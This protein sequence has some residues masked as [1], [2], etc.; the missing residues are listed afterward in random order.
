[1]IDCYFK[2]ES[3]AEK[4]GIDQAVELSATFGSEK[5]FIR[6]VDD[7]LMRAFGIAHQALERKLQRFHKQRIDKSHSGGIKNYV[8]GALKIF[9]LKK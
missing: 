2:D 6:E 8:E 7:R 9:R 1:V 3:S 4:G 5:I